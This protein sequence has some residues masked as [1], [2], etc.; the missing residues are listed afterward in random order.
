MAIETLSGDTLTNNKQTF[1]LG[2]VL[3]HVLLHLPDRRF[4]ISDVW[5]F[6][7]AQRQ[8]ERLQSL[9]MAL[10]SLLAIRFLQELFN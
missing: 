2:T 9:S 6:L 1:S 4:Y 5:R 3:Y 8:Q 10:S 7:R